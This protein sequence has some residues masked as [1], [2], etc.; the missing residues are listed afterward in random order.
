[1]DTAQ[2]LVVVACLLT[3]MVVGAVVGFLA[4][5]RPRPVEARCGCTHHFALHDPTTGRC[6]GS[7][8]S[9]EWTERYGWHQT[10]AECACQVYTGPA[11][12]Q[13]TWDGGVALLPPPREDAPRD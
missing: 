2:L 10:R 1:M 8:Q 11:P 9:G 3:G 6:K 13:L 5:R 12:V 7:V 4:R